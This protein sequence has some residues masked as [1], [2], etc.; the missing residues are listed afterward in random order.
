MIFFPF[1]RNANICIKHPFCINSLP[2]CIYFTLL[3][4]IYSDHFSSFFFL[5]NSLYSPG[6]F[7]NPTNCHRQVP[8]TRE[9]EGSYFPI[10]I[11]MAR[12]RNSPD[13]FPFW[14]TIISSSPWLI[15]DLGVGDVDH[16][17]IDVEVNFGAGL[18]LTL[19]PRCPLW[20]ER[21]VVHHSFSRG[22]T[23]HGTAENN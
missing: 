6:L 20:R 15:Q 9:G 2:F 14:W 22:R 13:I 18:E 16:V 21:K 8:S 5:L 19:Q 10:Y 12:E 4:T 1:S 3:I 23:K 17:A 7:P 11:H